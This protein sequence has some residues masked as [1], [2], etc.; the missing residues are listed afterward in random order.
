MFVDGQMPYAAAAD[1]AAADID[2]EAALFSP[3]AATL[4]LRHTLMLMLLPAEF[5]VIS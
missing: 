4:S 3:A 1:D 5:S 2:I